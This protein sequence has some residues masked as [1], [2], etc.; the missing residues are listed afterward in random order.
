MELAR[1][2]E[3]ALQRT[4]CVAEIRDEDVLEA[5]LPPPIAASLGLPEEARLRL[6]GSPSEGEWQAGYGSG[7]LAQLCSIAEG[8]V[9]RFRVELN[10]PLPK[11]ERV[12]REAQSVLSFTNAVGRVES[13]EEA[14][15]G[16]LVFDFRYWALSEERHEG[17]ISVAVNVEGGWS[18][19][20]PAT[21]S[22]FLSEHA[23]ARRAW[24]AT[25]G[26]PDPRPLYPAARALAGATARVEAAP[27]VARMQRRLRR[28]A[29]RVEDYYQ[30]LRH[31]A[32]RTRAKRRD[33]PESLLSK[34]A[35]IE[36]EKRRRHHD[37]R[38]RYSVS[39]RCGRIDVL[40]LRVLGLKLRARLRRRKIETR[41]SLGWNPIARQFD[42][43]LC[44]ACHRDCGVPALCDRL[45]MLCSACPPEC[46][47]CSRDACPACR[48]SGCRCGW[49]P[50][51]P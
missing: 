39:L 13:F 21:L 31:E 19:S 49:R 51:L 25:E 12:E 36:G 34:V 14:A 44:A 16:Y 48:P 47:G 7:L 30:A 28:D 17:L 18:P 3:S 1:F 9:R 33:S 45:H 4:G 6:R 41:T 20:L 38:R 11:R 15:L 43:W 10:P 50:A 2:V 46:P 23:E 8:G 40:A 24:S 5:L 27:F 37:L 32:E 22:R 29:H 26:T 42:R 35:A